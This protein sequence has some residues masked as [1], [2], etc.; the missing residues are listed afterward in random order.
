MAHYCKASVET[1]SSDFKRNESNPKGGC[2][3]KTQRIGLALLLVL[4]GQTVWA[5][6]I[7]LVQQE[8]RGSKTETSQVQMDKTHIRAESHANGESTVFLFD[9]TAKAIRVLNL[10]KKTYM[11]MDTAQMQQMQQQMAQM[12]EQL[13]NMPPQQ[14]AVMEQ[15]MRGR[16]GLGGGPP[17][18]AAIQYKQTGSDK[19]G[20][21]SCTKYE[22]YRGQ[23]KVAEVCAV[24]PKDL[25]VTPADFEAAKQLADYLKSLMPQMADQMTMYG[26]AAD[27]G[28][29]GMPVRR[30]TYSNG[31]VSSTSEVKE[32]KRGA[33]PASAFELPAGL[34]REGR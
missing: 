16:G 26:T 18:A 5:Q 28:F 3:L 33:I 27:Q 20:Q 7:T 22:G 4:I 15:M 32:F 14:R 11:Q 9:G 13:K 24:D 17:A 19:V 1:S 34:K 10:D 29:A 30:I 31:Q 6:G 12:Q 8:T 2:V 23:D 25:G 21:W